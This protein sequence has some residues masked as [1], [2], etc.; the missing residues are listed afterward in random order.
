L[1]R[2]NARCRNHS[3][4]ST[5]HDGSKAIASTGLESGVVPCADVFVQEVLDSS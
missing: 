5:T 4:V 3:F 1:T 2:R